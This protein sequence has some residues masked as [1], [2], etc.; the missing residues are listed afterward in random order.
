MGLLDKLDPVFIKGLGYLCPAPFPTAELVE[1]TIDEAIIKGRLLS[2]KLFFMN[3]KEQLNADL[4]NILAL[5]EVSESVTLGSGSTAVTGRA[6]L[7]ISG[8]TESTWNGGTAIAATAVLPKSVFSTEPKIHEILTVS[9]GRSYQIDSLAEE[10][11]AAWTV[12][13]V[14]DLKAR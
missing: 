5:D 3:F 2:Q 4:D 7:N 14:A 13:L 12:L 1:Q 6:V 11:T 9:N 10:S 8:Q